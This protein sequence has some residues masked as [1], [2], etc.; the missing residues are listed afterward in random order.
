MSS[1]IFFYST[2]EPND[3]TAWKVYKFKMMKIHF[4]TLK[5]FPISTY[6]IFSILFTYL[7][8]F[9][10][11][12]LNGR[13]S[14]TRASAQTSSFMLSL[15]Q[16]TRKWNLYWNSNECNE[17][18]VVNAI[19]WNLPEISHFLN[20]LKTTWIR[21]ENGKCLSPTHFSRFECEKYILKPLT[22][23]SYRDTNSPRK[24]IEAME[25]WKMC[26]VPPV[27]SAPPSS[28]IKSRWTK[29]EKKWKKVLLR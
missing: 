7:P 16:Q 25:N 8:S 4:F 6:P 19:K 29:L 18:G 23:G 20:N 28:M 22:R 11:F 14:S 24:E 26:S 2:Q 17:I 3:K 13:F 12:P 5:L 27:T 10:K 1:C 21:Y 9:W 15:P